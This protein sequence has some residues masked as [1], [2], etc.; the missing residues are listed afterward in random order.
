MHSLSCLDGTRQDAAT[1]IISSKTHF[2]DIIEEAL[3]YHH[4][5]DNKNFFAF[6]QKVH[7]ISKAWIQKLYPVADLIEILTKIDKTRNCY[8]SQGEFSTDKNRT[9]DN[10]ASLPGVW[11]DLDYYKVKYLAGRTGD[12]ILQLCLDRCVERNFPFP[13]RVNDSGQGL[14]VKWLSPE[15]IQKCD[16]LAFR[17]WKILMSRIVDEFRDL[18]ADPASADSVRV[19]RLVDTTNTKNGIICRTVYRSGRQ[20]DLDYLFHSFHCCL[21]KEPATEQKTEKASAVVRKTR[22]RR[23][24]AE[25]GENNVTWTEKRLSLDRF[26]DLRTL[27]KLRN[28]SEGIHEGHRDLFLY[29]TATFLSLHTSPEI[30]VQ[31]VMDLYY[32][33]FCPSV[34]AS[35]ARGWLSSIAHR[36]SA[37]SRGER[38]INPLNGKLCDPRYR[39][40]NDEL[41]R[42]LD[43]TE[44]EQ[45]HLKTIISKTEKKRRRAAKKF[46]SDRLAYLAT[47]KAKKEETTAEVVK[48]YR[49]GFCAKEIACMLGLTARWTRRVLETADISSNG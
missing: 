45:R 15:H 3:T 28:Q 18:G 24:V 1:E 5:P 34:S 46:K 2:P 23:T 47:E 8:I 44:D 35:E 43:I 20:Y 7:H 4:I 31:E 6:G 40:S 41:R 36:A 38:Y 21:E 17:K 12:E 10:L 22:T 11:A 32:K 42:L 39:Y 25:Y 49:D 37:A 19:L 9:E 29:F 33:E 14:Q 26:R 16:A 30:L 27:A 48:L 13:T